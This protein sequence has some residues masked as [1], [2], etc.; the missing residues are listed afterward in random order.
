VGS[1][2]LGI[3]P[4]GNFVNYDNSL[5][6]AGWGEICARS[7]RVRQAKFSLSITTIQITLHPK[8]NASIKKNQVLPINNHSKIFLIA[9]YLYYPLTRLEYQMQVLLFLDL[10]GHEKYLKTTVFGMTGNF[11]D[12]CMMLVAANNGVLTMTKVPFKCVVCFGLPILSIRA[13]DALW[14]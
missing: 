6:R 3:G 1:E 4:D 5:K 9:S 10:A 12:A 2:I 7:E 14:A 11:P 8:S 13:N